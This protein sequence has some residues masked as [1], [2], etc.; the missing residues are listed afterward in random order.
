MP[1]A[2]Q[3]SIISPSGDHGL[4]W[5]ANLVLTQGSGGMT[6]S[7]GWTVGN[8]GFVQQTFLGASIRN[9][10]L[11]AGFGDTTSSLSVSLV[12]DEYNKSDTTTLG[13]GDDIYHDGTKDQFSSLIPGTP[14]F[15]KF[16]KN[17][18]SIEQAWRKTFDDTYGYNTLNL[19]IVF[20]TTTTNGQIDSIPS[21]FHFLKSKS[22]T[23]PAQVNTWENKSIMYDNQLNDY[24]RGYGHFVFGGVLQSYTQNRG[25]TGNPVYSVSVQDPREILS[26]ATIVLNNYAGTTYNNKNLFNLFGFLE[27]DISE[28]L[29]ADIDSVRES[30][31]TLKKYVDQSSGE[32]SYGPRIE[33]TSIILDGTVPSPFYFPD[34]YKFPDYLVFGLQ[35]YPPKFPVTGQG[36][37][38]RSDQGIPIYRIF[39]AMETL[40]EMNG[41]LPD[42]FK[43]KGF[44][45]AI[46]F[47]GFKYVVD[48]TG[49]PIEKIPSMY[50]M[51]FDQ[52][53]LLS[54][55]Q[56][57]CDIISYDMSVS[58]LPVINHPGQ[59]W[60]YSKN[61]HYINTGQTD[62]IIAG[63]IRIDTIDKSKQPNYGAIAG[64]LDGLENR[65]IYVENRNVGY[66]VSNVTTNKFVVGAQEVEMHY[67]HS[68]KDRDN[69]QLR[70]HDNGLS[71]KYQLLQRNQWALETSLKQ[72][73]LPF[74][75]FLGKDAVT[76]PRGWGSYQQILLDSTSLDAFGVGNYYIATEMELRAALAGYKQWVKFLLQYN[77]RYVSE[78]GENQA[79]NGAIVRTLDASEMFPGTEDSIASAHAQYAANEYAVD[80]PRCVFNSD[81]NYVDSD[82]YPASQCSPP[83]GYPLYFKRAEKIGIPQAGYT[84]L[85]VARTQIQT[86]HEKAKNLEDKYIEKNTQNEVLIASL[87]KKKAGISPFESGKIDEMIVKIKEKTKLNDAAIASAGSLKARAKQSKDAAKHLSPSIDRI[88]E[89]SKKNSMKVFNFV[90]E[91]ASKHL[92]KKFLV[93]IPKMCNLGYNK[94]ISDYSDN[95]FNI[96]QGP[97]GFRPQPISSELNYYGSVAFQQEMLAKRSTLNAGNEYEH[98]LDNK[99]L[100]GPNSPVTPRYKYG[101]LKGNFNPI[102]ENWDFN[103]KPEP[104]GGFF[105]YAIFDK[106]LS[107]TEARS[108]PNSQLPLSTQSLLTP[109]DLTNFVGDNGRISCYVRYNNSQFLNLSSIP[110]DSV[111]QEKKTAAGLIP[112]ICEEVNNMDANNKVNFDAVGKRMSQ[113]LPPQPAVAFVK[114]ELS[115]KFYMPPKTHKVRTKV[116]GRDTELVTHDPIYTEGEK[117]NDSG[118]KVP[119]LSASEINL[120]FV[121]KRS[122]GGYD[123]KKV[124]NEDFVRYYSSML[125]G[126]II[127]TDLENLDDDNVYAIITVP[128]KIEATQDQRYMDGIMQSMNAPNLKNALTVDVVKGGV[129]GFDKPRSK[130]SQVDL[131]ARACN[132]DR[133]SANEINEAMM[134]YRNNKKNMVMGQI[135]VAIGF[136]SPSPVHPDVVALPLMSMENCYGPWQSQSIQN[137]SGGS[138]VRYTDIG[139]KIEFV[140][141]ESLAPWNYTGYQLMNE[142]GSLKAQFSNSMLLFMER[143]GFVMPEAPTG[144]S[145]A[146]ALRNEGPL[147]TSVS[148]SIGDSV[149]T[150][151]KMD[152]YTARFGKMQKQ[153]ED[154]IGRAARERQKM[155][156]E[157]NALIRK[158]MVKSATSA[159]IFGGLERKFSGMIS[160]AENIGEEIKEMPNKIFLSALPN[161]NADS[162]EVEQSATTMDSDTVEFTKGAWDWGTE[163]YNDMTTAGGDIAD[164]SQGVSMTPDHPNFPSPEFG[165]FD[166]N[167]WHNPSAP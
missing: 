132:D 105:N 14:V 164:T 158:G 27:Y 28:A 72:Q 49:I 126:D 43:D 55:A 23:G 107:F 127:N 47:R 149:K 120:T 46:E 65:D 106:S 152:L 69:L 21:H 160:S 157:K 59:S 167:I 97:F 11:N 113:S 104:Q 155:I 84:E 94:Q 52:I 143:G 92:G 115:E 29:Q 61:Q 22:G 100:L 125:D 103:Y 162:K 20:P 63:I 111:A 31:T 8:E 75:G 141:D 79:L 74:Y 58:L 50:F 1:F 5:P 26:N 101:A 36:L 33:D 166:V 145:L 163:K 102:S 86:N 78:V 151:V 13:T 128:G 114:C 30:K 139:G 17:L 123:G 165:N 4:N 147:V 110:K 68:N 54:F 138:R 146:K 60:L 42:E 136:A 45:G 148:V 51:D 64:Y 81:R 2:N 34:L 44:G 56:E 129:A 87:E 48:W 137:S 140:K 76:I 37:S 93:K 16:G 40:F 80:V 144:I 10:D 15:F 133:F 153:K 39:Q 108:A 71:N 73:V 66:E 85:V 24:R 118:C 124:N 112:D 121:P 90:K 134:Y 35:N 53:D 89:A 62:K 96:K 12:E 83:Y 150:T 98:Y 19:P 38:R 67:F 122:N 41:N 18:A 70:R 119:F 77:E 99:L 135:D 6:S 130:S 142:A 131:L 88:G 32:V 25:P 116:F 161:D 159:D 57:L 9:F 91:V 95:T 7:A 117:V 109:K 3:K 154:A 156:D 82:G